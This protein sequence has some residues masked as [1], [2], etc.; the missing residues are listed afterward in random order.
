M[1]KLLLMATLIIAMCAC[2]ER[3]TLNLRVEVV[4][5]TGER[6]TI[7][8][9]VTVHHKEDLD[10]SIDDYGCL[11]IDHFVKKVGTN[12]YEDVPMPCGIKDF[13]YTIISKIQD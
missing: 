13:K 5:K 9:A 6:E 2:T 4:Y 7:D 3:D 11:Y 1:K 10:I 12:T 8:V